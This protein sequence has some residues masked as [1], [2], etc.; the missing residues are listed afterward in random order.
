M[1]KKFQKI[2]FNSQIS[3]IVP[4]FKEISKILEA[5]CNELI[6]CSGNILFKLVKHI[7]L[8]WDQ[9]ENLNFLKILSARYEK[10]N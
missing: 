3:K 1:Q 6:R 2:I 8:L 4:F 9:E 10:L 5:A 7:L